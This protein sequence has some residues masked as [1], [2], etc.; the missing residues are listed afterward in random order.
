[1]KTYDNEPALYIALDVGSTT[2]VLAMTDGL[3]KKPRVR[4]VDTGDLVALEREVA[5]GRAKLKLAADV[6]VRFCYEAG[7]DGFWLHR[8]LCERGYSCLLIDPGSIPRTAK[9]KSAKTDRIDAQKLAGCLVRYWRGDES[10]FSVVRV[11][12]R[13]VE[14]VRTLERERKQLGD[15]VRRLRSR[16]WSVLATFGIR[17]PKGGKL[18]DPDELLDGNGQPLP[19]WTRERLHRTLTSID[20]VER[21]LEELEEQ[22]KVAVSRVPMLFLVYQML[23]S[24][25]GIGHISAFALTVEGLGWRT[26]A[27][28]REVGAS[29]GLAPTP[30]CSDQTHREQGINKAARSSLRSLM[31]QLAWLWTKHQPN[32]ALTRWFQ[33]RWGDAGKRARKVGIVALARKLYIALWK[34]GTHGEVPEGA[35]E[36]SRPALNAA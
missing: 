13:E 7:R 2:W 15:D 8:A 18:R 36:K 10:V 16:Y 24:M 12:P 11:P 27:N 14:D 25:K 6:P 31:V 19:G 26:F 34:Y 22:S 35:I 29:A 28:T 23:M 9:K 32:S 20:L 21:Q 17:R 1:M 5:E 30:H 4:R 3:R 33:R